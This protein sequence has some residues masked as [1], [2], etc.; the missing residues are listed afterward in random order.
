MWI[1][2]IT[3]ICSLV[4]IIGTQKITIPTIHSGISTTKEQVNVEVSTKEDVAT[5]NVKVTSQTPLNNDTSNKENNLSKRIDNP[6]ENKHETTDKITVLSHN[7]IVNKQE[8]I[9]ETKKTESNEVISKDDKIPT[10][11]KTNDNNIV[12][13]EDTVDNI[14]EIDSNDVIDKETINNNEDIKFT[15]IFYD[16]T[17]SIYDNDNITLL[18]IEYY[19]NNKLMYYS[20]IEN[21]NADTKSY[22]EKIY[23][24]DWDTNIEYLIRTDSYVNGQL[25]NSY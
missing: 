15:P 2:L 9:Y 8:N 25:V 18:R 7:E 14:E 13:N 19:K 5:P 6:D 3:M 22:I 4:F 12:I 1:K 23:H 20:A 11:E 10:Q 24:Y 21:F 16:R 17:T